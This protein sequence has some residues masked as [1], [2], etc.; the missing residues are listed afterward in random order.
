M[1]TPH[2]PEPAWDWTATVLVVLA[3]VLLAVLTFEVW[4]PH[5]GSHR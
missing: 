5:L 1:T 3:V 4:A 2:Q